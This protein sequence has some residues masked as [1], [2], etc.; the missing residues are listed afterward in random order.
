MVDSLMDGLRQS[1]VRMESVS[2]VAQAAVAGFQFVFIHPFEDGNGRLHRLL[3]Q[4]VLARRGIVSTGAALPISASILGEMHLYS[5]VL[6]EFSRRIMAVATFSFDDQGVLILQNG[7]ALEFFWR[8]PDLTRQTEFLAI[9]R[10]YDVAKADVL[11]I[12]DLPSQ[13]LGSL[14][15]WLDAGG[16][17]LSNNKRKQFA[18][19]TD[20]EIARIESAYSEAFQEK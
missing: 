19:L 3:F 15:K 5:E 18:E 7:P 12:V 6:E 11:A 10:N 16:G 8:Y 14:M 20:D 4:D 13:R 2:S 17:H 9:L 1:L